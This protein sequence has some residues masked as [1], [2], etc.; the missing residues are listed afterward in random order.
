VKVK[1]DWYLGLARIMANLTPIAV[2]ESLSGG[3]VP[4][5]FF[6]RIPEELRG[7]A[8]KYRDTLEAQHR[9]LRRRIEE[10]VRP[11]LERYGSSRASLGR[12]AQAHSAELGPLRSA[13]FLLLDRKED[14]LDLL[15][16]KLLYPR[17]NHFVEET[18]LL[19]LVALEKQ[20]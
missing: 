5:T 13:L 10:T 18:T 14:E 11:I 2:W 7:L 12:Y 3:K 20:D 16:K 4:D 15:I 17:G 6:I 1:T 19:P 9:I 8:E